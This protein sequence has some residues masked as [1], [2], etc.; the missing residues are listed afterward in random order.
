[1]KLE[2]VELRYVRMPLVTPFRTS[3]GTSHY[4]DTFLLRVTTAD[5]EGWAECGA[6]PDPLYSSEF[7]G[8]AELVLR[9]HLLPRVQALGATLGPE[10]VATAL[11]AVT[12]H[13]MAKHAVSYTH[14]TLP[15]KRI[16]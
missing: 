6:D 13:Q 8:G 1:M 16:V 5:A 3:F 4:K 15:T 2:Q 14:L 10:R 11:A 7:L 9:D 12:G